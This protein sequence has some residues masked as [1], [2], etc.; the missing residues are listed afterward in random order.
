MEYISVK[1]AA[2]KFGLSERRVQKLCET[3]RIDGCNMVSGVWL[4]PSN[5]TKPIDER[6][7]DIPEAYNCL[8]LKELCDEL[9]I[10]IAT[11]RNWIKLGKLTPE[12]TEKKTPYFSRIYVETLRTELQSGKNKALKSRR[13]KKFVSGNF[14]Y[15]SYVSEQCKNIMTLQ[16]LLVLASDNGID[17]SITTIQLLVADCALHLFISKNN[18]PLKE[19]NNLLLKFL[20]KQLSIGEYDCLIFDL[21]EDIDS[22]ICFCKKYPL[23]F[24][25][26]YIYEENE[27]ILGLIYISCKNIGNRKATGSYY[28]STKVVRKLISKLDFQENQKILDPCCGTGNFLL[29]LPEHF[30]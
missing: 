13:N 27:D 23:L 28:T 24:N 11:G 3:H 26:D 12:Y 8:T 18:I 19:H 25:M 16:K 15:N 6:L 21:I 10:S 2:T 4:I 5:A 20:L 1:D 17:L 29:Q 22:A 30:I 7:S 9:S 14:L